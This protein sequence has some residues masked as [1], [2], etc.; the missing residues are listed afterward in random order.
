M[1]V[2]SNVCFLVLICLPQEGDW[3]GGMEQVNIPRL[4]SFGSGPNCLFFSGGNPTLHARIL[5]LCVTVH[6]VCISVYSNHYSALAFSSGQA[7][8]TAS[9]SFDLDRDILGLDLVLWTPLNALGNSI[10]SNSSLCGVDN[11]VTA[12]YTDIAYNTY[13]CHLFLSCSENWK[14]SA[15][16]SKAKIQTPV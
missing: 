13:L 16:D 15:S 1:T 3:K 6:L 2:E 4:A 9:L 10:F 12:N 14:S 8:W 5:F 7:F 11:S